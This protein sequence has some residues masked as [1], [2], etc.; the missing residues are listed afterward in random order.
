MRSYSNHVHAGQRLASVIALANKDAERG[1]QRASKPLGPRPQP[2]SDD[3]VIDL[4]QQYLSGRRAV[5]LA[6]EFG[7]HPKTVPTVLKRAGIQIRHRGL[8][9]DQIDDAE[10]LY[11]QGQSLARIGQHFDVDHGTVWRQLKKRGVKCK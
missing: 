6:K 7:I 5:E 4:C 11:A 2:L 9:P 3:Q 8:T 1:I 10:R